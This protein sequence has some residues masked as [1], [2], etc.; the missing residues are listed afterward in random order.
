MNENGTAPRILVVDDEQAN[1]DL[2]ESFLEE[3]GYRLFSTRDPREVEDLCRSI[4]PDLL[5]LDLHMPYIS[6][7]EVMEQVLRLV[8]ADV[9]FP[10]LVLTADVSPAVRE[11]ALAAGAKDFLTK[12]LDGVEVLLRIRNLLETRSLHLRQQQA[13][14]NAEAAERRSRILAEASHRL[15]GSLDS[16]T[17][18]S[19]LARFLVTEIADY[20][21]IA[22]RQ[23]NGERE[24][25]GVAHRNPDL[26]AV[27]RQ[28]V[29][30]TGESPSAPGFLDAALR[31]TEPTLLS[32]I[33]EGML[34]DAAAAPEV[35]ELLRQLRPTSLI[36]VPLAASGG[37][38]G[39]MVIARED[40]SRPLHAED[41]DLAIEL[42]R[43]ATLAVE[44]ARLFHTAQQAVAAREQV[45][46]VV[47]HDLRNPLSTVAMGAQM[48]TESL[49]EPEH[50]GDRRYV[51]AIHRAAERMDKLIQDLLDITRWESGQLSISPSLQPLGPV[52]TEVV[53]MHRLS[54]GAEKIGLSLELAEPL[55]RAAI[56]AHRF[57]QV[58]SNLL[59]N[60]LKFTPD[61]GSIVVRAQR[62]GIGSVMISVI[63]SGPGL[64]AEQ[65][66]HIFSRFWQAERSDRRGIGLGLAIA[67]GLV[68]AH[69]GEIWVESE[70]GSGCRFHFTIPSEKSEAAES[71]GQHVPVPISAASPASRTS[72]D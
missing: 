62:Y 41:L 23:P 52:I 21:V 68:E 58:L 18:L 31:R 28:A 13:R 1:I 70:P 71:V 69:A 55:P 49:S 60:A 51:S 59:G 43:R 24:A 63:D 11:R 46:A 20:C 61:G 17:T 3:E 66:P 42:A 65:L 72:G 34:D 64:P 26:D 9:Y 35:A 16:T 5:L 30:L 8:P 2:L 12:P 40:G 37:V 22:L 38:A 57:H 67:K 45:L 19:T 10:I 32:E 4:L 6:G 25:A 56:D 15:A 29:Q 50:A 44:N 48:L 14:M 39:S 47:A 53:E 54:A 27:L 33:S 7:F 36:A